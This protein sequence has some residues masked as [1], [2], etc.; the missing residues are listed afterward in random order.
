MSFIYKVNTNPDEIY[1]TIEHFD[2]ANN[3]VLIDFFDDQE[4][5]KIVPLFNNGGLSSLSSMLLIQNYKLKSLN[6]G[7]VYIIQKEVIQTVLEQSQ[8]SFT[9]TSEHK[10]LIGATIKLGNDVAELFYKTKSFSQEELYVRSA[11]RSVTGNSELLNFR[12]QGNSKLI[13]RNV[14]QGNWNEIKVNGKY[15]ILFDIGATYF[16]SQT[17][18][19]ALISNREKDYI[20][21]NPGVIISHWDVDHYHVLKLFSDNLIK[22]F[23]FFICRSFLPNL[24]SQNLFNRIQQLI[25]EKI[26]SLNF[27]DHTNKKGVLGLVNQDIDKLLLFN[28]TKHSDRNKCGLSIAYKTLNSIAIL[29]GDLHY[30]QISDYI[31]PKVNYNANNHLVVPHH[32]GKAGALKYN[33][34]SN[35]KPSGAYISVGKNS[36]KHPLPANINK[37]KDLRFKVTSTKDINKDIEISL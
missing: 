24:T 36:Y 9:A 31:L 8:I 33:L 37:L 15:E 11:N 18:L 12:N 1:V 29:P 34:P 14:G 28:S 3:Q 17:N 32:G 6:E 10:L 7:S 21:H 2:A 4:F 5:D 30:K 27:L 13:I 35:V 19:L 26:F 16:E 22:N 20:A 23:K 25:P